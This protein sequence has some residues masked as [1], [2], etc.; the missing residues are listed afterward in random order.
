LISLF[1]FFWL[2]C[3]FQWD[4]HIPIVYSGDILLIGAIIKMLAFGDW[5]L[6]GLIHS[7]HLGAPGG[8]FLG[9]YPITDNFHFFW[10]KCISLFT[11]DPTVMINFYYLAT[12]PL[13][14]VTF[15]YAAKRFRVASPIAVSFGVLYAFLPYHILR[16]P[17][18]FLSAYYL[19]PLSVV[20][21]LWSWSKKPLF[22]Q[23]VHGTHYK[24]KIL[25]FKALF[26]VAV[27]FLMGIGGLYYAF[28]FSGFAILS[29]I[30][31]R[32]YRKCRYHFYSSLIVVLTVVSS[33]FLAS[34]P[35]LIYI[36]EHGKNPKV[37]LRTPHE[38]EFYGL[39]LTNLVTPRS[40][41]RIPLFASIQKRRPPAPVEGREENIGLIGLLGFLLLLFQA[42]RLGKKNSGLD[43]LQVLCINGAFLAMTGGFAIIISENLTPL[44]R[45]YNRIS[46]YLG[47]FSLLGI[48]F[49]LKSYQIR[50][51]KRGVYALSAL[52]LIVGAYD[53]INPDFAGYPSV[54]RTEYL[55]DQTFIQE[56]EKVSPPR[57]MILQLPFVPFPESPPTDQMTDYSHL[58][59][60]LFS[61]ELNWSYGS[62]KGRAEETPIFNASQIPL[63]LKQIKSMGY[64]GIYIDRFGF[65]DRGATLEAQLTQEL[66]TPPR[67]SENKRLSYFLLSL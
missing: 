16:Y 13:T 35:N 7:K 63:S 10:L 23:P 36:S 5:H 21:L 46:I 58:R 39:K 45:C 49:C 66:G 31:A 34:L 22:F 8:M 40:R 4:L 42:V 15:T 30:S 53:Q 47:L 24:L 26:S 60:F 55:S 9:D 29:G 56:I 38:A 1:L 27:A 33:F 19:L 14:V 2:V 50:L 37:P 65:V 20:I 67:V 52:F 3:D 11:S 18:L 44:I 41:H 51:G 32:M 12:F 43:K 62:M 17:H 25:S 28:F 64:Q 6:Y 57:A 59:G 54:N 61:K 48:C